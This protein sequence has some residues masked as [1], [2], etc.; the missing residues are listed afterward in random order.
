MRILS[1]NERNKIRAALIIIALVMA[2][3]VKPV[4]L[5]AYE[6]G[7][8]DTMQE[9]LATLRVDG[10][11][12]VLFEPA[13]GMFT[14]SETQG[15]MRFVP[16]GHVLL[17]TDFPYAPIREGYSFDGWQLDGN[18]VYGE[19]LTVNDHLTLEAIWVT[20]GESTYTPQGSSPTPA[21]T[22]TATPT[23]TQSPS[24]GAPNPNPTTSPITISLM[25]F[26]AVATLGIAAFSIVSLSMRHVVAVGSYRKNAMRF[27]RES[28]LASILGVGSKK[29]KDEKDKG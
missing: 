15:G 22:A 1:G 4:T 18:R 25:I 12:M 16:V 6:Y 14:E 19:Y 27:K 26:G 20:Y 7:E 13:P 29:D 5:A 8:Y 28:R 10:F 2:I 23:P 21:P 24:A 17:R 11:N 3:C 9:L